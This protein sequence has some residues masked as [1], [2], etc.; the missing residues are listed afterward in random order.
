MKTLTE[1][2]RTTLTQSPQDVIA[3]PIFLGVVLAAVIIRQFAPPPANVIVVSVTGALLVLDVAFA[4]YLKRSGAAMLVVTPD[5]ITFTREKKSANF[6]PA[7]L[8]RTPQTTLAFRLQSN[9][10]IGNQINYSLKLRDT[11][12]G[13]EMN[14]KTFGKRPVRRA[15]EAQGWPFADK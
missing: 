15:C 13:S 6:E 14:V 3:L 2:G 9:G 1:P 8:H 4:V 10:F 7:T 12:T 11:S 5:D